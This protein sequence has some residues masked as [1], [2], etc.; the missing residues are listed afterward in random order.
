MSNKHTEEYNNRVHILEEDLK[1]AEEAEKNAL[2][3]LKDASTWLSKME[4]NT[5]QIRAELQTLRNKD[6]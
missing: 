1:D 5:E 3:E 4:L 2:K 6:E